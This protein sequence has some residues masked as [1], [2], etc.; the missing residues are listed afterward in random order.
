[1][2]K[3]GTLKGRAKSLLL[4]PFQHFEDR[5][6]PRAHIWPLGILFRNLLDRVLA[7]IINALVSAHYKDVPKLD[8]ILGT[9]VVKGQF[10]L[11]M[12]DDG[13]K[14]TT[15]SSE[16]LFPI[17]GSNPFPHQLSKILFGVHCPGQVRLS[18]FLCSASDNRDKPGLFRS[19]RNDDISSASE[20]DI[21]RDLHT[22]GIPQANK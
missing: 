5:C 13:E 9:R 3:K 4:H 8:A 11:L 22:E 19:I 18:W 17:F 15:A 20:M 16:N 2:L 1:M 21:F 10:K 6:R 7:N 14:V 12:Q